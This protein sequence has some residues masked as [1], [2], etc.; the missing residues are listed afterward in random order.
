MQISLDTSTASQAELTALIALLASLG[1][2]LPE[3]EGFTKISGPEDRPDFQPLAVLTADEMRQVVEDEGNETASGAAPEAGSPATSD[4]AS[5]STQ[6]GTPEL[7]ADGIPW[8]ERIHA[9]TKTKTQ[10]GVWTKKRKVD[11]VLYGQVH[12]ELQE[13]YASLA[14]GTAAATSAPPPP[15]ASP[16]PEGNAAPP[17]PPT[18]QAA[19]PPPTPAA[20]AP[21][22]PAPP[23]VA[24]ASAA[25]SGQFAG[26][27]DFVNAINAIK[28]PYPYNEL[29]AICEDLSAMYEDLSVSRFSE[30]KD[31]ETYWPQFHDMAKAAAA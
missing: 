12:A 2:R 10:Q 7:D 24:G 4:T 29:N 11:E 9:S 1:G 3:R 18:T 13:Q 22:A 14:S 17:P 27:P 20:S 26:F 25:P 8:D 21:T 15:A 30:M 28:S 16:A 31:H 19:P 23:P 6:T 5:A